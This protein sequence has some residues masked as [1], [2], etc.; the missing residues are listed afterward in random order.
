[1]SSF[2]TISISFFYLLLLFGIAYWVER[3]SVKGKSVSS[4]PYIYAFSLAVY[5]TA[6]TFYG[7]VGRAAQTSGLP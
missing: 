6:W 7:S 3:K 5:C 2:W 4:N 1:M